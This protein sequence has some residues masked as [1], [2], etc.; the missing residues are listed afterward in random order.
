V[1]KAMRLGLGILIT[2]AAQ[3][4][5]QTT[6]LRES[7]IECASSMLGLGGRRGRIPRRE[8]NTRYGEIAVGWQTLQYGVSRAEI[9]SVKGD[10]ED[11]WMEGRMGCGTGVVSLGGDGDVS[12]C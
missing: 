3:E 7:G 8:V 6:S 11:T 9:T 4:T 10:E 12:G 1:G 5:G 2:V